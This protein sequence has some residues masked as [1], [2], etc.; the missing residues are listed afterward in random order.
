MKPLSIFVFALFFL[1]VVAH[2]QVQVTHLVLFKLK[3]GVLK[4]DEHLLKAIEMLKTLPT[5]IPFISDW[6]AGENFSTRPIAYDYGLHAVFE[7]RNDLQQYLVHP[8]HVEAVNLWKQV[9]DWNIVDFE[10]TP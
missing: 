10:E 4:N 3:P 8:A 9:A 7:S 6:S 2:G 1:S 5:K